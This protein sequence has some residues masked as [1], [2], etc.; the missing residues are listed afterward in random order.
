MSDFGILADTASK[1]EAIL[2][3]AEHH[4]DAGRIIDLV[5][6]SLVA[7]RY[8]IG[9]AIRAEARAFQSG[10]WSVHGNVSVTFDGGLRYAARIAEE[11][12]RR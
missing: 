7:Q 8:A 10:Q 4:P 2:G 3:T 11:A 12:G 6:A 1:I 5:Q 9:R